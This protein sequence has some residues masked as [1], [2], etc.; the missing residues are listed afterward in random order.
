MSC[1]S[2]DVDLAK[3]SCDAATLQRTQRI[4]KF[5]DSMRRDVAAAGGGLAGLSAAIEFADRSYRTVVFKTKKVAWEASARNGGQALAGLTGKP[6]AEAI[7]GN[8]NR[9]GTFLRILHRRFGGGKLL[10]TPAL[11]AGMTHHRLRDMP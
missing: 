6:A 4:S 10:R 9:F 8:A 3:R 2:A 11:V 1:L 5:E 7:D